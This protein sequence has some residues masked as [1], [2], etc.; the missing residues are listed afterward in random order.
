MCLQFL[1][2]ELK[3]ATKKNPCHKGP[4]TRLPVIFIA[5][6]EPPHHSSN[7]NLALLALQTYKLLCGQSGLK[8]HL[9]LCVCVFVCIPLGCGLLD[10]A[11]AGPGLLP[12]DPVSRL[13]SATSRLLLLSIRACRA[14]SLLKP[15][16]MMC[17]RARSSTYPTNDRKY[18]CCMET[19]EED[20]M[21]MIIISTITR[22]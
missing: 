18:I 6:K 7:L 8:V 1:V 22:L 2:N 10:S 9:G 11:A 15:I 12:E 3:Q 21:H 5:F 16:S 20:Y 13:F 14:A 19:T 17:L 4:L